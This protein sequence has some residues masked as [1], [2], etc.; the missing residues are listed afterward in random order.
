[1]F[2]PDD[3]AK[4]YYASNPG[5]T[6]TAANLYAA[7]QVPI[8]V[9]RCIEAGENIA[10]ETVLS[11]DKYLPIVE[12]AHRRGYQVGMIYLALEDAEVSRSRVAQRV[13][14][15]GHDVPADRIRPRWRRSL[16]NLIKFAPLLDGLL[17]YHSTSARGLALLA[18]KYAGRVLWYGARK[19]PALRLRLGAQRLAKSGPRTGGIPL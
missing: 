5:V 12:H 3:F 15:G 9:E 14:A 8:D 2:N 17:V 4:V 11:S 1:M 18:E 16:D 19:F 10:V 13:A 7:N 6:W